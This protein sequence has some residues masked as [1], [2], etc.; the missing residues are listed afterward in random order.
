MFEACSGWIAV[1]IIGSLTACV[2]FVVDVGVATVSD[3]KLGYCTKN[4][5]LSREACC[6]GK[7][8]LFGVQSELAEQCK[9]FQVWTNNYVGSF[10]IYVGMALAFGII[11]SSATMLTKRSLPAVAP[12]NSGKTDGSKSPSENVPAGK[13]MYMAAGSGIPEYV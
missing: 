5:L 12:D 10:A 3:W 6:D 4:P 8:P 13:V 9:H 11:S 7:T 1:A 2:A